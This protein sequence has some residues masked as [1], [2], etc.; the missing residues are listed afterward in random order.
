MLL[1]T[2][3]EEKCKY[4]Y[5]KLRFWG[6][7]NMTE[8]MFHDKP[9]GGIYVGSLRIESIFS[10][11]VYPSGLVQGLA[12]NSFDQMNSVSLSL[13]VLIFLVQI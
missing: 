3:F 9:M 10:T 8:Q 13:S 5:F 7:F 4:M 12:Q 6:L 11:S 1:V 2:Q